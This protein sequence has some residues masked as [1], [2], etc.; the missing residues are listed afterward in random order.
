MRSIA[1]TLDGA[2]A[3]ACGGAQGG[4]GHAAAASAPLEVPL[5]VL[6]LDPGWTSERLRRTLEGA[7]RILAA[8]DIRLSPRRLERAVLVGAAERLR[9]LEPGAAAT[10]FERLGRAGTRRPVAAVFAR[11]TLMT[12]PFDAEA[13]GRANTRGRG[14]L[15]DSVWMTLP[16]RDEAIALAHE[17]WHVLANSGEHVELAGNLMSSRTTG[18]NEDLT[19]EQ[20]AVARDAALW[21]G[22]ASAVR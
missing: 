11:D 7:A 1:S 5:D 2:S 15:A 9:D 8:C 10:L 20:C 4:F 18:D 22:L 19:A 3:P 21:A 17:L 14:W 6:V 16:L 12:T 13:F